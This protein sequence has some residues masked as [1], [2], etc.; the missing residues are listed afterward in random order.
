ME[1]T[2][3]RTSAYENEKP[4]DEAYIGKLT[5]ID[6]RNAKSFDEFT[7]KSG[8]DFLATGTDHQ[9]TPTGITRN[10]GQRDCWKIELGSLEEFVAFTEKYGSTVFNGQCIEIYDDYRE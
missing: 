10:L 3:T 1:F 4:C 5:I 6:T 9:V 2:I 7:R 8:N